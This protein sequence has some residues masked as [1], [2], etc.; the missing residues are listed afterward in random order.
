MQCDYYSEDNTRTDTMSKVDIIGEDDSLSK[1][2]DMVMPEPEPSED[3]AKNLAM[4]QVNLT[5]R[6]ISSCLLPTKDRLT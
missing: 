3:P 2:Y 5:K 1:F 4:T 6:M